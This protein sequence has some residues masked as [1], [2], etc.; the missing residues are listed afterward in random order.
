M[1]T[2]YEGK[3]EEQAPTGPPKIAI[4]KIDQWPSHAAQVTTTVLINGEACG[5][6]RFAH[7]DDFTAFKKCLMAGGLWD[8]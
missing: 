8:E 5:M 6:I 4:K 1:S 3:G 7:Q 2:G